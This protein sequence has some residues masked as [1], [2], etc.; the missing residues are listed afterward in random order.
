MSG[1][2]RQV[3]K[4]DSPCTAAAV[5]QGQQQQVAR[6]LAEIAEESIARAAGHLAGLRRGASGADDGA[7]GATGRRRPRGQPQALADARDPLR[8]DD[9]VLEEP[10]APADHPPRLGLGH[11]VQQ[12]G[13]LECLA[14]DRSRRPAPRPRARQLVAERRERGQAA[15]A[16][17]RLRRGRG[18]NARARRSG[19]ARAGSCAA[20]ARSRETPREESER[21]HPAHGAPGAPRAA[22]I[23]TSSSRTR[24][25]DTRAS[26]RGM[27]ADEPRVDGV[28]AEA[29]GWPARRT[30]A[31][32][33]QRIVDQ[34]SLAR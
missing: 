12:R 13:E 32:P 2:R 15:R 19:A 8:A 34:R 1:D 14:R 7:P 5:G 6:V 26:S 31:Q 33:A 30:A 22:S 18:A 28:E 10:D 11:V 25:A 9:V 16:G 20:S 23:A 27:S 29:E 24:S 3:A 21:V 17:G 4:G